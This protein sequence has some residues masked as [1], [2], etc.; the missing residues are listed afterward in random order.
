MHEKE[1][2]PTVNH[3]T[4]EVEPPATEEVQLEAPGTSPTSPARPTEASR[5]D[6]VAEARETGE[7][8]A[9]DELGTVPFRFDDP[10]WDDAFDSYHNPTLR[11]CCK[12]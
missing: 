5:V 12:R 9:R 4:P 10:F 1:Y 6:E 8:H 7:S 11:V 3:R 2:G